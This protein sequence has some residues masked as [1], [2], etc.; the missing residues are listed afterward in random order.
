MKLKRYE[1]NPILVANG[2]RAWESGAVF[3][4]GATLGEDGLIYILYRAIPKG[5]TKSPHGRG[6]KNYISSIGCATSE[7]GIHFVRFHDPIVEPNDAF[8][9]FGCEDP[10]ITRLEGKGSVLYLITY[11]ALSDPAFSGHGNRVALAS[12]KDFRTLQKHGVVIPDLES[13]DAVI[14]PEL[15][16]GKIAMLHRVLPETQIVY[17][18]DWE[19]LI[20]PEK[21]FWR[22]Y[23]DSLQEFIIMRPKY[24]WE[25]KKI[26][27]GPPPIKTQAG[28]LL[29]YHGV[30]AAHVYRVGAVLLDMEE[31]SRVIARSP[32]PILEPEEEYERIGDVNNVV[33]PCGAVVREG[34]LHVYYGGADKCC[35]LATSPLNDLLEHLSIFKTG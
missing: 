32:Y 19:Q 16:S 23:R 29:L 26:G 12:T 28:W 14:F 9:R 1:H 22:K 6:F 24:E 20:Y 15:V 31:P 3:N 18:K 25:T 33:F 35:C 13:K 8:D 21:G 4:C 5:Y 17:F 11:T 7:D 2:N 27:P 30:D 10:R 34:L